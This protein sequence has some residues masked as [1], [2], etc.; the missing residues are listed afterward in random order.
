[1]QAISYRRFGAPDVLELTELP[2]PRPGR[3]EVLVRV[4]AAALN[5]KDVLVRKGRFRAIS[6]RHFPRIPGYDFAGRVEALGPGASG[7]RVG[8]A[9]FGMVQAWRGGTCAELVS[10]PADELALSPERVTPLEAAA[11]PLA[12]L[13]ALSALRDLARVGP[14]ARVCVHGASGGVGLYAVQIAKL[15]GAHVTAVCSARNDAHVRAYGAD[16]VAPYDAPG[17]PRLEPASFDAFFDVFGNR[18]WPAPRSLLR[19]D[20]R[21]VTTVPSLRSVLHDLTTRFSRQPARLVV[22]R[23]RRADLTTIARWV[24]DGKLR[25]VVDRVFP[26]EASRDAH[27]YVE[28]KRA[29]GKVVIAISPRDAT[30]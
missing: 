15:L 7:V 14:G 29:R 5:P 20:G 17:G 12:S 25:A 13:T 2:D 9:V 8:D 4:A 6:G 30:R 26:L 24:D 22:V 1:M 11:L 3:G 21:Y 28:T 27:A 23:S 16:D 10:C 18:P 19:R